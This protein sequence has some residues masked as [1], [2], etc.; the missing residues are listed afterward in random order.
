MSLLPAWGHPGPGCPQLCTGYAEPPEPHA[1]PRVLP[2]RLRCPRSSPQVEIVLPSGRATAASSDPRRLCCASRV[3]GWVTQD[4]PWKEQ[5]SAPAR[6]QQRRG[7]PHL[8]LLQGE[9]FS[10]KES[11]VIEMEIL[12]GMSVLMTP[13]M[14][15]R[16]NNFF[17][18]YIWLKILI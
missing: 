4:L 6:P 17:P 14:A 5:S 1:V 7:Q 13:L 16:L 9:Q 3:L 10:T 18:L 2:A 11:I 12:V 8:L 15:E